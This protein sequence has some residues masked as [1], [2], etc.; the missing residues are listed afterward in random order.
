MK[1][2]IGQFS[3]RVAKPEVNYAK[4]REMT[5]AAAAQGA[6]FIVFPELWHSGYD[7]EN[8]EAYAKG[9]PELLSALSGLAKESGMYLFAGSLLHHSEQGVQNSQAIFDPTGKLLGRY[10]KVHLFRLMDEDKYLV[11]GDAPQVIDTP[12]GKAGL[13][14]CYDLRFPELFFAYEDVNFVVVPAQWPQPRL[15]HWQTLVKARAIENQWY[16][17]AVN[18]SGISGSTKFG[19]HSTVVDPWGETLVEGGEGEELLFATLDLER[20]AEARSRIPVHQD[21]RLR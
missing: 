15:A 14:I 12:W 11:A 17:I 4:V 1:V 7:L 9:E 6:E 18:R 5:L 10:P 13:A 3:V 21:R 8:A 16:I 19:G 2:A 20:V